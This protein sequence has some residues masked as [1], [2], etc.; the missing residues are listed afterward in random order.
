MY[1]LLMPKISIPKPRKSTG[2]PR[3][4]KRKKDDL[5]PEQQER[6]VQQRK[7]TKYVQK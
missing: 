5:T 4:E 1:E 3:R 6:K 2:L 7:T